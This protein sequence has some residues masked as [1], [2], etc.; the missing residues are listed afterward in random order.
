M[1]DGTL[2]FKAIMSGIPSHH[3]AT[4]SR[5]RP[6]H[7]VHGSGGMAS[8]RKGVL[9][10][11]RPQPPIRP[12]PYHRYYHPPTSSLASQTLPPHVLTPSPPM[13]MPSTSTH[14]VLHPPRP[15]P[16]AH[17]PLSPLPKPS[18]TM[19]PLASPH[20][21]G[22]MLGWTPRAPHPR[23]AARSH[24]S[25]RPVVPTGPPTHPVPSPI[26]LHTPSKSSPRLKVASA[27]VTKPIPKGVASTPT[28]IIAPV[29]LPITSGNTPSWLKGGYR[30]QPPPSPSTLVGP[31]AVETWCK[32]RIEL[33]KS[34]ID[35]KSE[36][37]RD[38]RKVMQELDVP[39]ISEE[40]AQIRSI[41]TDFWKAR[42][43]QRK[44]EA[45]LTNA[46][47]EVFRIDL[48]MDHINSKINRLRGYVR[49]IEGGWSDERV[50]TGG[51]PT[52][53][54]KSDPSAEIKT[55]KTTKQEDVEMKEK[56]ENPL[57]SPKPSS[58]SA[59]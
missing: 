4:S 26:P 25:V 3:H 15:H 41:R 49:F 59:C 43:R 12:P 38:L 30:P 57:H 36:S 6:I 7:P 53:S 54:D 46:E 20:A 56:P 32:E 27:G 5:Q 51:V 1:L 29:P 55:G 8:P 18:G 9:S 24:L 19:A 28:P 16:H 21:P 10:Q 35:G 39:A 40:I 42:E 13:P 44:S 22:P 17:L 31:A 52:E 34:V 48:Q 2:A 33:I 45:Q 47:G 23:Q 37:L 50:L 58:R 14:P 11:S